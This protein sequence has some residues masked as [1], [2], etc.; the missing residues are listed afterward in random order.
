[1]AQEIMGKNK[2]SYGSHTEAAI[3]ST[4]I[5]SSKLTDEGYNY[6]EDP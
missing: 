6:Q 2:K 1:M 5:I 3:A 4:K